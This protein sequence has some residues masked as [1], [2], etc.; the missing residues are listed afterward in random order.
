MGKTRARAT[1][2]S[3]NPM[4]KA[5]FYGVG[6][7]PK[8]R[9]GRERAPAAATTMMMMMMMMAAAAAAAAEARNQTDGYNLG[10]QKGGC[11][12]IPK[13]AATTARGGDHYWKFSFKERFDDSCRHRRKGTRNRRRFSLLP[14]FVIILQGRRARTYS[15]AH[16]I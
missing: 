9:D 3:R 5:K 7:R 4:L 8:S 2:A 16:S 1:D 6:G 12:S 15:C 14:K 13:P 10:C 11:K